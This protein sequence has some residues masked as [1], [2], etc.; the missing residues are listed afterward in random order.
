[1]SWQLDE[2]LQSQAAVILEAFGDAVSIQDPS[3]TILYQNSKHKKLMGDRAGKKCYE[4]YNQRADVCPCCHLLTAFKEKRTVR[5]TGSSR[6]SRRGLCHVE[7]TAFPLFDE[8]GTLVAG[9]E[10]VRDI[11]EQTLFDERLRLITCDLE[12]KS[13]KLMSANRELES[14]SYTLS[15]DVRNYLSRISIAADALTCEVAD[16]SGGTAAFL[17]ASIKESVVAMDEMID[18]I[19]RLS[20]A[21]LKT[22]AQDDV[23]LGSM[24]EELAAELRIL[25]PDHPVALAIGA[26]LDMKGD[27]QLLQ[28]MLRNLL[29]NAWKYT[30]SIP[31]PRVSFAVEEHGGKKIFTIRDNGIGFDM[32]ESGRLFK[33]FS[34]LSNSAA[35]N[36]SG[37]GLATARRVIVCHGGEMWAEGEP[38]KGAAV[39]FAIPLSQG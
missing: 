23:D 38:G 12:E 15:H 24:A 22:I 25:Y 6:H 1:M 5:R 4:G 14:F 11:T 18:A 29:G 9:I 7:I 27:R 32:K 28:V 16:S 8:S 36:G 39:F 30:Q 10:A 31:A 17:L 2:F 13:W 37:I 20:S 35:V 34:R 19:L 33:P 26:G 21:G 3:L